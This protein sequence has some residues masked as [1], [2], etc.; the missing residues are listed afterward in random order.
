MAIC[1]YILGNRVYRSRSRCRIKYMYIL[2]ARRV[3]IEC[4]HHPEELFVTIYLALFS[5]DCMIFA[6]CTKNTI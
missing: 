6:I 3:H 2:L 4:F 1:V 5:S